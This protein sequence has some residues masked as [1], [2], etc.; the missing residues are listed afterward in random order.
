MATEKALDALNSK[1]IDNNVY[2]APNIWPIANS[3]QNDSINRKFYDALPPKGY[4]AIMGI[5]D[6]KDNYYIY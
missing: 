1:N 4:D 3:P 5:M 2:H 6:V